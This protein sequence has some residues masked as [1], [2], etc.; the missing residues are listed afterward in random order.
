[1]KIEITT[2]SDS[3][4]CECCGHSYGTGGEVRIDGE[5]VLS[6]PASAGCFGGT[7][8]DEGELLVMAL[9]KLGHEITVDGDPYQVTTHD[10][11]YH[12]PLEP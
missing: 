6:K 12:G 2:D 10:E 9:T 1:L 5:L 8:F 7:H 4:D 11:E 3:A